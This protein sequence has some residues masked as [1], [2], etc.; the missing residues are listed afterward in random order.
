M[1]EL[2]SIDGFARSGLLFLLPFAWFALLLL[3]IRSRSGLHRV[4]RIA[5]LVV[6]GLVVT[7]LIFTLAGPYTRSR[8]L[9]PLQ[10]IWVRDVSASVSGS[11]QA[12][13]QRRRRALQALEP[14]ADS[15]EIR[16]AADAAGEDDP[17]PDP[18]ASDPRAALA[19]ARSVL[20][21]E[22]RNRVVLFTDGRFST[23]LLPEDWVP[24]PAETGHVYRIPVSHPTGPDP[25]ARALILPP[26]VDQ[27]APFSIEA[28][29][30]SD[31]P[32]AGE[33]RVTGAGPE[34]IRRPIH[35]PGAGT[36]YLSIRLGP[37]EQGKYG[38]RVALTVPE[39]REPGNNLLETTLT[40]GQPP[41]VLVVDDEDRDGGSVRAALAAQGVAV[42]VDHRIPIHDLPAFR[43]VVL[44]N[45]NRALSRD[46]AVALRAFVEQQAGGL[47]VL[48]G[49]RG[50]GLGAYRD[51]P[52]AEVLPLVALPPPPRV[53][54]PPDQPEQP[55]PP[56]KN[57][58]SP[59][60]K[61]AVFESRGPASSI[62]VL[63]LIDKSGSM[64]EKSFPSRIPAI[65]FAKE[66][67]IATAE[68]MTPDDRLGVVAFD[69]TTPHVVIP[70]GPVQDRQTMASQVARLQPGGGT[71]FLPVLQTA[72]G[73]LRNDPS[74][75]KHVILLTDGQRMDRERY[76]D[77]EFKHLL[78]RMT[79]AKITLST[80][81]VGH[82][83]EGEF[84]IQLATWGKG[85]FY[86]ATSPEDVPR[87]YTLE[88]D[89]L[90]AQAGRK[91]EKKQDMNPRDVPPDTV[92]SNTEKTTPGETPAGGAATTRPRTSPPPRKPIR[93]RL[94]RPHPVLSGLSPPFPDLTGLD[95]TRARSTSWVALT[96][97][98]KNQ[99]VLATGPFGAGNVMVFTADL[100]GEWSGGWLTWKDFP[101]FVAQTLRFV[102]QPPSPV[103]PL[104]RNGRNHGPELD[105]TG[106]DAGTLARLDALTQARPLPRPVP[107]LW[108]GES[109][110]PRKE[111]LPPYALLLVV[112]LIPLEAFLRRLSR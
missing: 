90:L 27:G 102:G 53:E 101:A 22:S 17:A 49:K 108:P 16:F 103:P 87:I 23:H 46:E 67:A 93:L 106:D 80:V 2:V 55:G 96:T 59:G 12:A 42:T 51:S 33:I 65:Q 4:G 76:Q 9:D 10:W 70:P 38:L 105:R 57:P 29:F 69:N 77:R 41:R 100:A 83:F 73:L 3:S 63:L 60:K 74:R 18:T 50:H 86:F 72:A 13:Y 99:P 79:D 8:E 15:L 71:R 43:A 66:A 84:L 54:P 112:L 35:F 61:P 91:G 34:P 19:W 44:R 14:G 11:S 39:D 78:G 109:D 107:G 48:G 111:P 89:R 6:R 97:R 75:I 25:R 21:P 5:T 58:P 110:H 40:V 32:A 20:S 85:K 64:G 47:L 7:A 24:V 30:E 26:R 68:T 28:R 94:A 36:R 1:L 88:A 92:P 81:G 37:L 82:Q 98:E 104:L 31:G 52:L 62:T 95:P 45:R 56:E